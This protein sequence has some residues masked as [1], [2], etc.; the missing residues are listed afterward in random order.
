MCSTGTQHVCSMDTKWL[1]H[2]L[3][4]QTEIWTH[5]WWT[6]S[7][8]VRSGKSELKQTEAY[9]RVSPFTLCL[10]DIQ[11]NKASLFPLI[12]RREMPSS[13]FRGWNQQTFEISLTLLMSQSIKWLSV[14]DLFNK[15]VFGPSPDENESSDEM[16]PVIRQ[17][18]MEAV[19]CKVW[20]MHAPVWES[21]KVNPLLLDVSTDLLSYGLSSSAESQ[22]CCTQRG[23]LNRILAL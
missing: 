1:L 9:T 12:K 11:N 17:Q 6:A 5:V 16:K 21:R 13:D 22:S 23:R 4:V 2:M 19:V 20:T 15:I 10:A 18:L 14:A 3:F 8:L 7:P